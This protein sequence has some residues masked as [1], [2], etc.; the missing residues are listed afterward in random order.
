MKGEPHS[1]EHLAPN[2]FGKVPV[3]DH[4]DFRVIE[5]AAKMS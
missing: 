5:T 3:I 4:D 1:P 2:A